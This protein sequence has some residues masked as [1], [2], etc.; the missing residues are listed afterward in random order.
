MTETGKY[1]IVYFA[2]ATGMWKGIPAG[3]ALNLHPILT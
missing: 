1:L 3:I 2:G